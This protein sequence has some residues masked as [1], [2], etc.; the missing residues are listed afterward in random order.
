MRTLK[1]IEY[2]KCETPEVLGKVK[3]T[4]RLIEQAGRGYEEMKLKLHMIRTGTFCKEESVENEKLPEDDLEEVKIDEEKMKNKKKKRKMSVN[5]KFNYYEV[6][7][8]DDCGE[9]FD[10]K[11]LKKN[12]M[13]LALKHHPDKLGEDYDE[14]AK[15][16][17]LKVTL[18]RFKMP[19][20]R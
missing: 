20:K 3:L 13:K 11:R 14:E 19:G 4:S 12:Y 5:L 1:A 18:N 16:K 10:E 8:F 15:K 9:D 6:M 7:G 17:W 2:G